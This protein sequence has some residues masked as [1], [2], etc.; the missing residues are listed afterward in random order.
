MVLM[1]QTI[2]IS[3]RWGSQQERCPSEGILVS[4]RLAQAETTILRG[5]QPPCPCWRRYHLNGYEI[6]MKTRQ[7]IFLDR[8]Q[9]QR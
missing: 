9:V 8:I 2:E 3:F 6:H 1:I 7:R 4:A 5:P